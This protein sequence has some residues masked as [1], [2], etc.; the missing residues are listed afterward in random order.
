MYS[1]QVEKLERYLDQWSDHADADAV[2]HPKNAEGV[3]LAFSL[4][5]HG[6][7]SD[8]GIAIALNE[9][10]YRTTG[11]WGER[12][13][14]GDTVRP[15]LKNPF[16]LGKVQSQGEWIDGRHPSLIPESLFEQCQAIRAQR[17]GWTVRAKSTKRVYPL[18]G[19][20]V[21]ARC[22]KPM[23]G[24]PNWQDRRYYRDPQRSNHTCTQL[25]IQADKAEQA[26]IQYLSKIRLPRDWRECILAQG[27][28]SEERNA[29]EAKR[30]RLENQLERSQKLYLM[31]D[32]GE[33]EYLQ[34]RTDLT[35]KLAAIRP[36]EDPD[37]ESA[38]LMLENIGQLLAQATPNELE[39]I[40]HAL[41][42]TV[43]L[44]S[45]KH[46]P[47][48]AIEPKP[49]LK[50]LMD[51]SQLP[52]RP[53][54]DDP[55]SGPDGGGHFSYFQDSFERSQMVAGPKSDTIGFDVGIEVEMM[56]ESNREPVASV[57]VTMENPPCLC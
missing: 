50:V 13:F 54:P 18:S 14:E 17:R 6:N 15:M 55:T 47:V 29:L 52:E 33:A 46:G 1:E 22:Q 2:P 24:Q 28:T 12:L 56:A 43:Y 23:R 20:V 8:H 40:F 3:R 57:C 31:G 26:V 32:M 27:L 35:A 45:G 44:D 41:L 21:C 38:A 10:G 11:N 4:Y 36:V 39:D 30:Q 37:L 53:D 42:T 49:F 51:V 9:A 16:Y 48:V 34:A 7:I 19:L 5:A 25:Q